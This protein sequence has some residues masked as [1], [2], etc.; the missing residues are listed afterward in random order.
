V[1]PV[2]DDAEHG[3]GTSVA[4]G[5]RWT[6]VG[7][8]LVQVVRLGSSVVLARL[9]APEAFGVMAMVLVVTTFLEVSKDLGTG[10]A[11]VQ[12]PRIDRSLPSSLFALNLGLGVVLMLG[13]I[14]VAPVVAAVYDDPQVV[15]VLRVTSLAV[16]VSSTA[17]VHQ[18]LLRRE[19]R[20]AR[21][22]A[23]HV[24]NAV[25]TAA[26]SIGLALLGL[27]VWALAWGLV[28]GTLAGAVAAWVL[29]GWRPTALP[30]WADVRSIADF[31]LNLSGAQLA[32][33]LLFNL[34]KVIVGR[35]LGAATL[36]IYSIA[37][38]VLMQPVS[39]ATQALH[40]VLFAAMSRIQEDRAALADA[41]VRTGAGVALVVFPAVGGVAA[42]ADVLVPTVLGE[43][44]VDAVPVL[45]ALAPG[46]AVQSLITTTVTLYLV[47]GRTDLML[48]WTLVSGTVV[49]V[50]WYLGRA[51][52]LVGVAT[53]FSL[54]VVLLAYPAFAIP[55]SQIDL[56]VRRFV[57][58]LLPC[59]AATTVM[60]AATRGLAWALP[61]D[62]VV[63]V[64]RLAL[65]VM[66]GATTYGLIVWRWD[67]PGLRD[68][69]RLTSR[70]GGATAR[71]VPPPPQESR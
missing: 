8:V 41:Y 33:F 66:V 9:L 47:R 31:S 60:V 3:L 61:S 27:G 22:A 29:S 52:G 7:Q 51:W 49:A 25:V 10:A 53:A 15:P 19:L 13:V 39:T 36:G 20:F 50:A 63:P 24:S 55:F 12:R 11:L 28:A 30:R 58:T 37:Q 56:R 46:I 67:V 62:A 65:L 48:R 32:T 23:V 35:F 64:V 69:R 70:T 68:L 57:T 17:V 4:V 54:A 34:D 42:V 43:R 40:D 18:A 26:A 44:W 71:S 2:P 6:G 59:T 21:L 1:N 45:I 5:T 16:L 38:R 14:A